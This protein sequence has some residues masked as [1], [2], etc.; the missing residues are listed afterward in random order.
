MRRILYI[1]AGCLCAA[2]A[3]CREFSNPFAGEKPLAKVGDK[4]LLLSDI[5]SVFTPGITR[6]D[7][8][9]L[10][11]SYVDMW[12]K[13]QLKAQEAERI[14]KNDQQ[15]IDRLVEEYRHSLLNYRLDQYYV[16]RMLD[17]TFTEGEIEAYYTEHRSD[18]I[19]DRPIVKGE[20]VKLPANY[21][22]QAKLKEL[23]MSNREADRQ[24][25]LDICLKNN[26]TR[27]E[28]TT[29]TDFSKFATQLPGRQDDAIVKKEDVQEIASDSDRYFFRIAAFRQAG[30]VIPLERVSS[31]IRRV[32]YNQR[33]SEIV[34]WYEDSI[35]QAALQN[36]MLIVNVK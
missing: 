23:M 13:Q 15:D 30:D 24:D 16:N 9:Q 14:L 11:E 2:V 36:K 4:S 35:Y 25:F 26:F 33:R 5:E 22:Q 6:S 3:G 8:V 12:I 21:R 28:F 19:L 31:V 27:Q 32:L 7:S 20:I 18:F 29:W 17:T 10:L 1:A 34:R